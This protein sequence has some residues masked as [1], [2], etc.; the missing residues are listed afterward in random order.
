MSRAKVKAVKAWALVV[1]GKLQG[2]EADHPILYDTKVGGEV[3]GVDGDPER[4]VIRVEIRPVPARKRKPRR[5][6]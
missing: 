5:K 3:W 2:L 1:G 6:A 4:E